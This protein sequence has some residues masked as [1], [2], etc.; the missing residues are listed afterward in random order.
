MTNPTLITTPFAENG[1]KNIIPESVG[2]N[3][4]N[5]TM[6]AGFPPITQQKI[7]EGGIPPE[8][9]D[10]NGMF[11]LV[12]QHLVHLNNG[13]SYEFNQE[14]ADKVGGYPLNARLMLSNGDI[15]QSTIA[16]NVNNPNLDMSGWVKKGSLI[17]V[18]SIAELLAI[19]NPKDGDIANVLSFHSGLGKGGG[20][21][22]YD[23]SKS[24]TNDGVVIFNGWVR[25]LSEKLLTTD[26]VGLTGEPSVDGDSTNKLKLL[27]AAVIGFTGTEIRLLGKFNTTEPVIFTELKDCLIN[28]GE[29]SYVTGVDAIHNSN[30]CRGA[31]NLLNCENTHIKYVKVVGARMPYARLYQEDGQGGICLSASDGCTVS[32]CDISETHTWSISAVNCSNTKV[33]LNKCKGVARQSGINIWIDAGENNVAFDNQVSEC[34]LYGIEIE[35]SLLGIQKGAV[36]YNN[37]SY[38][39]MY[40][41]CVVGRQSNVSVYDN[42]IDHCM[43]GLAL[44]IESTISN[45]INVVRENTVNSCLYGLLIGRALAS[46]FTKNNVDGKLTGD[47]YYIATPYS[48]IIGTDNPTT[49]YLIDSTAKTNGFAW[50]VGNAVRINGVET[51]ISAI[52]NISSYGAYSGPS[53]KGTETFLKVTLA[54]SVSNL[55][56]GD[57]LYVK[58]SSL[59]ITTYGAIFSAGS[60]SIF[61]QNSFKNVT[62]G[63][64][65]D[66]V[67][68]VGNLRFINNVV[69]ATTG[70]FRFTNTLSTA[71]VNVNIEKLSLLDSTRII[72][73]A[74]SN[75]L[76]SIKNLFSNK[77]LKTNKA[78]DIAYPTAVTYGQFGSSPTA[79]LTRDYYSN[80]RLCLVGLSVDYV[81]LKAVS[82]GPALIVN[83]TNTNLTLAQNKSTETTN[84]EVGAI[85]PINLNGNFTYK[86]TTTGSTND[87]G[88]ASLVFRLHCI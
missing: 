5:A 47:L 31:I 42:Q 65:I 6:Q 79:N 81:A 52:E 1:D 85:N 10:F 54:N 88:Y 11:N 22:A 51:T 12:T 39:S 33:F 56:V 37:T 9:N 73:N 57:F 23:S 50:A 40:G 74:E 35:S 43:W 20:W 67:D 21:F 59:A 24:S 7:S 48:S 84:E 72:N 66:L 26:M 2:A 69:S 36:A 55:K 76:N 17:E 25:D 68:N 87:L 60:F 14:H 19:Q 15:V 64:R 18:E 3:P 45:Q 46:N 38:N 82:G 77:Q 71:A 62:Y 41:M 63:I 53:Y 49:I 44:S 28:F 80:E 61:E 86:L 13:M 8:R 58:N 4:Q 34:G 75:S 30:N 32:L 29:F 78:I 16:N 70:A 27:A 83:D